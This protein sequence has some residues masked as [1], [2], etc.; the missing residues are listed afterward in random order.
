MKLVKHFVVHIPN[1]HNQKTVSD[2][3]FELH[4]DRRWNT[5]ETANTVIDVLETPLNYK[6]D[7]KKGDQIFVDATL[8]LQAINVKGFENENN[9]LIDREK[10]LYRVDPNFIIAYK[11]KGVK[12]WIGFEDNLLCK[13]VVTQKKNEDKVLKSGIIIPGIIERS[14]DRLEVVIINKNISIQGV[15][16]LDNVISKK[17][18]EVD[19][20]LNKAPLVWL[21]NKDV[22]AIKL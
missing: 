7:I 11:L 5:K 18:M 4:Q 8:I 13:K 14:E 16:K 17:L 19:V 6:G 3:G 15:K 12:D 1:L 22:L 21:R 10:Q 2:S 9:Y 20:W